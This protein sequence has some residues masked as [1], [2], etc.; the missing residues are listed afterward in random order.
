MKM[1]F[2]SILILSFLFEISCQIAGENLSK[3]HGANDME[4]ML[5]YY[6]FVI[7]YLKVLNRKLLENNY[8]ISTEDESLLLLLLKKMSEHNMISPSGMRV[9]EKLRGI[10]ALR[11][12]NVMVKTK[13]RTKYMHWRHGR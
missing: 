7:Q 4:T 6:P 11:R 3:R 1:K 9:L 8:S 2:V 13:P 5:Y 10:F 12:E